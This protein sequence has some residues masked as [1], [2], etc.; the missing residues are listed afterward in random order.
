M[1]DRDVVVYLMKENI[2]LREQL[3]ESQE[4]SDFWFQEYQELR[5]QHAE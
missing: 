1:E 3:K 4:T 2:Q 5:K